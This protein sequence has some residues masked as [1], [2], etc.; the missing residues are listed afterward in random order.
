[1]RNRFLVSYDVSDA[2][3]LRKMFKK[4]HGYGD[5]VQYSVFLC[6]LSPKEK[7]LML[8]AISRIVNHDQDRVMIVDLGP[9]EGRGAECIEFCG[10]Q[11]EVQESVAVVV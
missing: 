7:V 4:M 10:R 3:R 5:P 11:D 9:V 6:R 1:M 2:K 8:E